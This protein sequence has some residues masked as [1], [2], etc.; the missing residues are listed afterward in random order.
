MTVASVR[1]KLLVATPQLADPNFERA[2]LLIIDHTSSEGALG[3]VLNRPTKVQ[4]RGAA[5]GWNDVISPPRVVFIGGP[6][7]YS[8]LI[9]VASVR[10]DKETSS[11]KRITQHIGIV[12]LSLT[13]ES[14]SGLVNL[15]IFAGYAAWEPGQLEAEMAQESW[16]VLGLDPDDPFASAPSDLWWQVFER[17]DD[18]AMRRLR[19]YPR[20]LSDN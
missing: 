10:D 6:I 15:R 12:D 11:W 16:F 8:A 19:F 20:S 18:A 17:Q 14:V 1:G 2:V 13:P 5:F 9:G 3:V 4:S 7:S